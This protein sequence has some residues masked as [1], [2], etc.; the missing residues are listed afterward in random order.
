MSRYFQ[1]PAPIL[2]G[3][4]ASSLIGMGP[5]GRVDRRGY[6]HSALDQSRFV[7]FADKL[8]E[9]ATVKSRNLSLGYLPL[10]FRC[11]RPGRSGH[12]QSLPPSLRSTCNIPALIM[13]TSLSGTALA[14]PS[15]NKLSSGRSVG[16][17]S[18]HVITG[19]KAKSPQ[20]L[21]HQPS[22]ARTA[23]PFRSTRM[24]PQS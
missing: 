16:G 4:T 12:N 7:P 22:R 18:V 17:K 24:A 2:R 9:Y 3:K 11:H 15:R 6:G 23:L 13:V 20:I 21:N 5:A 1:A 10:P 19:M 8:R 14:T